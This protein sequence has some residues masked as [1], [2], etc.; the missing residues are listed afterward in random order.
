MFEKEVIE[1]FEDM[2]CA[3]IV[4]GEKEISDE[5]LAT[6]VAAKRQDDMS[7]KVAYEVCMSIESLRPEPE[8]AMT[9]PQAKAILEMDCSAY[10][11]GQGLDPGEVSDGWDDMVDLAELIT[12]ERLLGDHEIQAEETYQG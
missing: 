4:H 12:D 2:K 5:A 11:E 6:L 1:A 9:Y 8:F 3:M 7:R 10:G